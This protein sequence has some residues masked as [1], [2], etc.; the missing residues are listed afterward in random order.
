MSTGDINQEKLNREKYG[1]QDDDVISRTYRENVTGGDFYCYKNA[2]KYMR[3]FCGN[4]HKSGNIMDLK[5]SRD[6]ID[7][8]ILFHEQNDTKKHIQEIEEK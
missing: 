5:K 7:R 2:E 6:Y 4:S 1:N 8:M 3:R